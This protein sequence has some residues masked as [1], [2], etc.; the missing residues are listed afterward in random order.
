M[1]RVVSRCSRDL[2]WQSIMVVSKP[3]DAP[4]S[5]RASKCY[6]RREATETANFA[7]QPY[8]SYGHLK[9]AR[10]WSKCRYANSTDNA[11]LHAREVI[12]YSYECLRDFSSGY[13]PR[14]K[15]I[16][17]E[18]QVFENEDVSPVRLSKGPHTSKCRQ[19]LSHLVSMIET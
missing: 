18:S 17:S 10:N 15:P 1:P 19:Q 16:V 8:F 5:S 6:A 3:D 7:A 14:V 9:F 13:G 2:R 12:S 4:S 11:E